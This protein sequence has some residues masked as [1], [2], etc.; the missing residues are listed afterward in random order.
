MAIFV[1]SFNLNMY[2]ILLASHS[3]F[4]W[5]VVA[6]LLFAVILAFS[7]WRG[8]KTF[9]VFDNR[10]RHWTATLVHIQF[11]I[12]V[13]LYFIS[14]V[15]EYFWR[16]YKDTVHQRELRFFSMEHS[17]TM[18]LVVVLVTLGSAKAKRKGTGRLKFKTMFVWYLI[19]LLFILVMIPWPFS[20]LV[21]RPYLRPF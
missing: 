14:P 11:V 3:L 20:P 13:T 1:K 19:A 16:Y 4:R 6:G 18:L 7:G 21:N 5:L 10:V 12:G 2:S 9:S 8:N 17:T 15:V